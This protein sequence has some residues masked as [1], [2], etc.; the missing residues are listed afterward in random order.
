MDVLHCLDLGVSQEAIGNLFYLFICSKFVA[1]KNQPE[2]LMVLWETINEYYKRV[3]P[4][5]RIS[6]LTL[7]MIKRSSK[8]P[9]FRGKGAETRHMVPFAME[10]SAW[11]Y[12]QDKSELNQSIKDMFAN[13]LSFYGTMG[14]EPFDKQRAADSAKNFLMLYADVSKR[15]AENVW[16]VKPKFHMFQEMA[17]YQGN[18]SGDPSRFWAY[19]DESFVGIIGQIA[20]SRG[21]K[22]CPTTT[23]ENVIAKYRA[24]D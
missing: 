9:R 20:H 16:L 2:Q 22:R 11:M 3:S 6:N 5:T 21:G 7:E 17:E 15:T 24:C 18:T 19:A 4:P 1:G 23:P 13:L 14:T 12:E 10:L 8:S